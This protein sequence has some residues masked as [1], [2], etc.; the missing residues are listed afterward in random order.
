MYAF[1]HIVMM[2]AHMHIVAMYAFA[3]IAATTTN[4]VSRRATRDRLNNPAA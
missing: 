1:V 2:N 4:R 3:H